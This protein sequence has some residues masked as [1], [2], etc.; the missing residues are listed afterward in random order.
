MDLRIRGS[1]VRKKVVAIE[2]AWERQKAVA[3]GKMARKTWAR[4]SRQSRLIEDSFRGK[5]IGLV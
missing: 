1:C 5:S 3:R 2:K 4:P